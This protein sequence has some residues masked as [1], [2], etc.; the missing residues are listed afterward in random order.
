MISDMEINGDRE[1][2]VT[3]ASERFHPV[4]INLDSCNRITGIVGDLDYFGFSQPQAGELIGDAFDFM[5]GIDEPFDSILEFVETPNGR[6]VHVY[7]Q[8]SDRGREL[9]LIDV[10]DERDQRQ[11][12]QQK[13]NE[14]ALLN[15]KQ[16][17]LLNELGLVNEAL[18]E[19]KDRGGKSGKL[20]EPIS[21]LDVS[22]ISDTPGVNSDVCRLFTIRT[23]TRS[24]SGGSGFN[25]ACC[26]T[27]AQ[28]G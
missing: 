27:F 9:T 10:S 4:V 2:L 18:N 25:Q 20:A 16:V 21:G 23:R 1:W 11:S 22:R 3:L 19:K 5:Y 6:A 7:F 8:A 28:H 14:L 12:L 24:D 13:S 15:R 17:K 26:T